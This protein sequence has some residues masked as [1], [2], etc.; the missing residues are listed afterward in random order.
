MEFHT[1]ELSAQPV[2]FIRTQTKVTEI[3]DKIGEC[4]GQIAPYVGANAAGGPLCRY[5]EWDGEGGVMEVAMP[6]QAPMDAKGNIEA[7]ELP[8]GKAAVVTHVGAY[9]GLAE[10]WEALKGWMAEQKME[11]RGDPWE[12]Y[13]DDCTVTPAEKLRTRIVWPI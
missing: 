13:M 1:E 3:G 11:C 6:V 9:D 8:G 5:N 7:G 4:L 10:T 2:V 12:Q